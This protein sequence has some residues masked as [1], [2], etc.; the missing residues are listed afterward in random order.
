MKKIVSLLTIGILVTLFYSPSF[1][2]AK[3]AIVLTDNLNVRT[4]PGT[5]YDKLQQVHTN[6]VYPILTED[7]DWVEIDLGDG[8]GW[9][10]T[11]YITISDD[12]DSETVTNSSDGVSDAENENATNTNSDEVVM[13]NDYTH[14]RNEPSTDGDI[15][16]FADKG[17]SFKVLSEK[18]QWL[19]IENN[20]TKGFVH[21]RLISDKT[22][23]RKNG[24]HNKTIVLDAGHGG[25]DVGAIGISGVYEKI[26]TYQTT[27]EL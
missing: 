12:G 11:E 14:I 2:A 5:D 8:T 22:I 27:M 21:Q 25:R 26:F 7:N 19:E 24:L 3:E 13:T 17:E 23:D 1:I 15:I 6:E 9:V 4:G 16:Y 10:T 18:D 20:E